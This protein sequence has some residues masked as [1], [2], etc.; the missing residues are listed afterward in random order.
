LRIIAFRA[1]GEH[2][3]MP[4]RADS[5]RPLQEWYGIA[6]AANWASPRDVK[7]AYGSASIVEGN[8]VVFNIAGNKYRLV[9]K[10]NYAYRIG[11]VRFVG[12]H[13]E[14]DDIDAG[15]I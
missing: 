5:E 2:W 10:F 11:Y 15:T 7:A 14:Y 8:R 3:Q 6:K 13:E 9:V 12:K 4:G 1:L